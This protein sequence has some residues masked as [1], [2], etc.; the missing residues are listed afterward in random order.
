MASLAHW[1]AGV[2]KDR[3]MNRRTLLKSTGGL[4]LGLLA[5]R[6]TIAFA[7]G[8]PSSEEFPALAITVNDDG[9]DI[10]EGLTAGRYAV[11]VVNAGTGP[12]HSS[13]GR[14]PDGVT[15]DEVMAFMTSESEDLPDWF[16][17]AGYVGLPDWPAPGETITGVVD[18]PAGNYF[19]F[20]PFSA[21]AAFTTVGAG[22]IPTT[23]PESTATVELT[24]MYFILPDA[25]LPTGTSVLKISNIGAIPHEFQ[26]LAV[27]EGTTA[28]Q[29]VALFALPFDATPTPGDP[30]AEMM[31]NYA[32]VA[33]SSIIGAGITSW[34]DAD[35][36]PG[37]YAVLCAL[38]FPDGVP[39]AMQ[40]M[41]E[42]V[43]IG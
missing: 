27:P 6:S 3:T 38:P 24:E 31:A 37:T 23:E 9:Y 15:Q 25:G 10:P 28:D 4:T 2:G 20:D 14:L 19:M 17:N 8:T 35:L 40:G 13:L 42:I 32:P 5:A 34:I 11:S 36:A 12:S 7:Q 33:A 41:L 30:L 29:I 39:H 22:E 26:V 18:L 21:R 16:V 1:A 43:T